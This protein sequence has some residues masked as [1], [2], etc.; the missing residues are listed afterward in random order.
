MKL[1]FLESNRVEKNVKILS[2]N[3]VEVT[4]EESHCVIEDKDIKNN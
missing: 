2:F 4:G 3:L 1:Y